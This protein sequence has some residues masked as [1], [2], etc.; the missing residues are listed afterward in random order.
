M[1]PN[2]A[3][4]RELNDQMRSN[5]FI[6]PNSRYMITDGIT[7]LP[8]E[9]LTLIIEKIQNFSDF[10]NNNDPHKEHDFGAI[11]VGDNK[12]FWK[13]DYYAPDMMHGS[14]DPGDPEKTVRVLTVM[15]AGEY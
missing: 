7:A 14:E 4:I 5:W 13:I 8:P 12:I 11:E 3:K 15:L 10:V 1:K 9:E 6:H 2:T